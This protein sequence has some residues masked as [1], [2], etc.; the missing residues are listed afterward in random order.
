MDVPLIRKV[1]LTVSFVQSLLFHPG[2]DDPDTI[3]AL[4]LSL[5]NFA[6]RTFGFLLLEDSTE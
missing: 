1:V 6:N 2:L 5:E 3:V 4:L